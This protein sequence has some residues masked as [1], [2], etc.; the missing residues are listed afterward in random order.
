MVN[1]DRH[2]ANAPAS[3]WQLVDVAPPPVVNA[4]VGVPSFD[5]RFLVH[6]ADIAFVRRVTPALT[7]QPS[8]FTGTLELRDGWLCVRPE[9]RGHA[10]NSAA[11]LNALIALLPPELRR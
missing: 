11:Y 2:A 6:C 1:G 3:I 9:G 4:T 5:D 8:K 7:A 10:P